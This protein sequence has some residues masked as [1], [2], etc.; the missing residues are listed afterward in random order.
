MLFWGAVIAM[1]LVVLTAYFT[2]R[3]G[4]DETFNLLIGSAY[5]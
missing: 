3:I 1:V 2:N 4:E 5:Q